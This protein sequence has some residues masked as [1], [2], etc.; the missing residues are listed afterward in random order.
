MPAQLKAIPKW[1]YDDL[2]LVIPQGTDYDTW[3]ER[4]IELQKTRA[5]MMWWLGDWALYGEEKF[6]ELH[7]QAIELYSVESIRTAVRI[8]KRIP[9][10]RRRPL[11]FSAH[12]IIAKYDELTQ[13]E[14]LDLGVAGAWTREQ[15]REEV[16]MYD[17]YLAAKE[18]DVARTRGTFRVVGEPGAGTA[19]E[20]EQLEMGEPQPDPAQ[21]RAP[22]PGTE[23]TVAK[24]RLS[25]TLT[26]AS[27]GRPAAQPE[28]ELEPDPEP[29][30]PEP[31]PAPHHEILYGREVEMPSTEGMTS[32]E[33]AEFL[34]QLARA[35][36]PQ[37]VHVAL[38][39]VLSERD[40]LLRLLKS[41]RLNQQMG[42]SMS[43]GLRDAI[44]SLEMAR[45][46]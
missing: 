21:E 27:L 4:G 36:L 34:R 11:A 14:F 19:A 31:D 8:C 43:A 32:D 40:R 33:A 25:G 9:L 12:Q 13:D 6:G 39:I 35:S 23:L 5:A 26:L 24:P 29:A 2:G 15:M 17:L 7:A 28:P 42:F 10:Q 3:A 20:P 38:E 1:R 30:A 18:E 45:V 37:S 46:G 44:A 16:K 22:E 41:A